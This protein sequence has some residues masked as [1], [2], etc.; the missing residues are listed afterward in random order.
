M[1]VIDKEERMCWNSRGEF[2]GEGETGAES[3]RK[4]SLEKRGLGREKVT[5]NSMAFRSYTSRL[6]FVSKLLW[7]QRTGH[8]RWPICISGVMCRL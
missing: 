8:L 6:G 1:S 3:G 5:G 4:W 7:Q 2:H